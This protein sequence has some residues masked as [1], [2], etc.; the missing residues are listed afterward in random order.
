VIENLL[1]LELNHCVNQTPLCYN[2]LEREKSHRMCDWGS[3]RKPW[4]KGKVSNL[5]RSKQS[6][7]STATRSRYLQIHFEIVIE[8]WKCYDHGSWS[9]EHYWLNCSWL[10]RIE[11]W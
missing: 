2:L 7:S 10:K 4:K 1:T 11:L 6:D 8:N 3:R 5:W 9:D